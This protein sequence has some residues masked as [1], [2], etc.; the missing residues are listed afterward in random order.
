MGNVHVKYSATKR[1]QFPFLCWVF[2]LTLY[3]FARP[4]LQWLKG[5]DIKIGA[6]LVG[7]CEI[8]KFIYV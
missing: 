6:K 2:V 4:F 1:L 7:W 8:S 5:F 3:S